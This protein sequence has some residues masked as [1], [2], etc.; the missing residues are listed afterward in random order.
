LI[1]RD[2]RKLKIKKQKKLSKNNNSLFKLLRRDEFISVSKCLSISVH[3]MG[4]QARKR[5]LTE[6]IPCEII[7]VGY[8]CSR[9]VGN[10][11]K[12]NKSKRRLRE[13]GLKL[14]PIYGTPG[15]DYVV[16]GRYQDTI[17][18]PFCELEKSFIRALTKIQKKT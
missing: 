5:Q 4:L 3:G 2:I 8:T 18:I 14:L 1:S 12:R 9:K 13:I 6:N 7:R 17:T 11:V 10:A 16:I 15:W